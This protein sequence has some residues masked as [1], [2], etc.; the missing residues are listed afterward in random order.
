MGF[1]TIGLDLEFMPAVRTLYLN[2]DGSRYLNTTDGEKSPKAATA[3]FMKRHKVSKE[4][5]SYERVHF[6]ELS[7]SFLRQ[8]KLKYNPSGYHMWVVFE[9]KLTNEVLTNYYDQNP[10]MAMRVDTEID[11][12]GIAQ[13]EWSEEY[14]W[15]GGILLSR[16]LALDKN[17]P[18]YHDEAYVPKGMRRLT[19]RDFERALLAGAE[20]DDGLVDIAVRSV[21]EDDPIQDIRDRP[22]FETPTR[23]IEAMSDQE[24]LLFRWLREMEWEDLADMLL[25][26]Y[27]DLPQGPDD[28]RCGVVVTI[29]KE[30]GLREQLATDHEGNEFAIPAE[31]NKE[32]MELIHQN[33]SSDWEYD[34]I[35]ESLWDLLEGLQAAV[36]LQLRT[37]NQFTVY[38][39]PKKD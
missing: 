17:D 13:S 34:Q 8:H 16:D 3:Q 23:A 19:V 32:L 29:L 7:E 39:K 35:K 18:F 30:L 9:R 26:D 10:T 21:T 15:T 38:Q 36:S 27:T 31:G 5:T 2:P 24:Q 28:E 1:L 12:W 6:T 14:R 20:F 33:T 22:V 37:D 4:R 25:I 11:K